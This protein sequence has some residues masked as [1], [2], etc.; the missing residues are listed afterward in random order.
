MMNRYTNISAQ[1]G[2]EVEYEYVDAQDLRIGDKLV[3][4]ETSHLDDEIDI[5]D[6]AQYKKN[7]GYVF[8]RVN[9]CIYP[10]LQRRLDQPVRIVARPR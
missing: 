9:G 2:K 4:G 5:L 7:P 3:S 6:I 8:L 1:T 10:E